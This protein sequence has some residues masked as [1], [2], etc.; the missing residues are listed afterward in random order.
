MRTEALFPP[1]DDRRRGNDS[2]T[3][4]LAE[5]EQRVAR[6]S[7]TPTIDMDAF[8]AELLAF[9]F[10]R[11]VPLDDLLAWTIARMED[12]VVHQNHP[13]YLGLFNPAPTFPAQC[14]DRIAASFNPQLATATTSPAA[15]EIEAHVIKAVARR[16]GLGQ[17]A[18]GHFTSGG[19]EANFTALVCALTKAEPQFAAGGS[20]AFAGQPVFY[21]SRDSHLAWIKIA[22]Q[23][24]IG[25][26]AARLVATD[27]SGRMDPHALT[28]AI[29]AD[30]AAG[31]VPFM[32]VATAGT[33][34]AGMVDPLEACARIA[35]GNGMWFHVD[36]AWGGGLIA[37]DRLRGPLAGIEQADS[38]TIDA[39]KWFAVT[40]GCGMFLT[41]QPDILPA[42]FNVS[43]SYMP[44]HS[45]SV[46]PYVTTSQWSRRFLGL[47]LFLSLGAGGWPAYATHVE[48]SIELA[49]LLVHC[50]EERGWSVVNDP[51]LAVVCLEPPPGSRT[52]R[53]IVRHVLASGGAWV[54]VAMFEGREIVRTCV[55][56]GETT[57]ADIFTVMEL[58]ENARC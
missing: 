30:R 31:C 16:A 25:R 47:R 36:A 43:A 29:D 58:L 57:P 52:V 56:H 28:A 27:G 37:S 4:M 49:R 51:A 2:L 22:H 32:V 48:R 19:S 42:A 53:D 55:T 26:A 38:I 14:A 7:V 5:A 41:R 33:T 10:E 39:H 24:G 3:I 13:R 17:H 8:R 45:P 15:V 18:G 23:A 1:P 46:D 40:M 35:G 6:G 50:A 9:D 21:I 20:R 12:G 44:S 54:S 34:N 11:T